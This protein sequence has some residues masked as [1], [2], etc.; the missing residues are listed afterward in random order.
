MRPFGIFS[1]DDMESIFPGL[2][3]RRLFEWQSHGYIVKLRKGW[4]CLPEFLNESYSSWLIA[5]LVHSPSYISLETALSYYE[6]I[7][8][9]VYMTTSVATNRPLSKEMA[10]QYFTYS[11]IRQELY[12]GYALLDTGFYNRK[13]KIACMEKAIFDFFYFRTEYSTLKS[14]R[15][16]RFNESVIRDA[17]IM[18]RL[19]QYL[20]QARNSALEK[21]I[22]RMFKTV[23]NA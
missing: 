4:Y 10:G 3:K 11:S 16:L 2:D 23:F 7:P 14:I 18:D 21:R 19:E 22:R 20:S 13:V 12:M 15:E 8:E 1:I 9:G 5:N 6:V 17:L